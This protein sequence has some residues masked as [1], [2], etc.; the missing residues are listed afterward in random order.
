PTGDIDAHESHDCAVRQLPSGTVTFLFTDIEGSTR[1]LHELGDGYGDALAAHR[2]LVR[3]AFA[4]HG[5][6][7]VGTQ[8]GEFFYALA[9]ATDVVLILS[10]VPLKQER[11]EEALELAD[12]SAA[13]AAEVGWRWWESGALGTAAECALKLE[14]PEDARDRLRRAL[15]IEHEI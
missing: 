15:V 5:G 14:R 1:L 8:G 10:Y 11:F 7:E 3:E 2:D 13:L 6:G 4:A 9:T 12:R